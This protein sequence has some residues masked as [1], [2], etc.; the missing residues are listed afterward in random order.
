MMRDLLDLAAL[1]TTADV[2]PLTGENRIIVKEGLTLIG[3]GICPGIQSLK[4]VAG[5]DGKRPSAGLLSFSLIPRIN[6]AGRM[7]DANDVI[8]L[9]LTDSVD[10]ADRLSLWLDTLNSAEAADRRRS[11]SGSPLPA[12]RKGDR[13]CDCTCL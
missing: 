12:R 11:I 2:V 9:F 4:R 7:A 10:E 13:P 1:G 6:A 3:N 5:I 8:K